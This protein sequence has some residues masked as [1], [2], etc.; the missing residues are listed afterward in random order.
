MDYF[1]LFPDN[2][3]PLLSWR[4]KPPAVS[5]KRIKLRWKSN[6]KADFFCAHERIDHLERCGNLRLKGNWVTDNLPEG[7]HLFWVFGVDDVGNRGKPLEHEWV[8][9]K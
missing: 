1:P 3:P 7:K 6:E 5:G 4:R 8:V 2:I 9:G